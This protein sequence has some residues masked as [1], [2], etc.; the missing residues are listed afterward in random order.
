MNNIQEIQYKQ[1]VAQR[2]KEQ[3]TKKKAQEQIQIAIDL[4]HLAITE[5]IM[6]SEDEYL[7][8]FADEMLA[9]A[10]RATYFNF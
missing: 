1:E 2:V 4:Y 6:G 8:K 10:S 7:I 5:I 9:K 3:A